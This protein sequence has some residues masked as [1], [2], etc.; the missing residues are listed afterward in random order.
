[1]T[2]GRSSPTACAPEAAA[3][4]DPVITGKGIS[5]PSAEKRL[6]LVSL[7]SALADILLEG[8]RYREKLTELSGPDLEKEI[9]ANLGIEPDSV[10][11]I[12]A[13]GLA[14]SSLTDQSIALFAQ[15]SYALA[16]SKTLE[17][18]KQAEFDNPLTAAAAWLRAGDACIFKNDSPAAIAYYR[19][20][21]TLAIPESSVRLKATLLSHLSRALHAG[22][23]D[24]PEKPASQVLLQQSLEAIQTAAT[25]IPRE[26]MPEWWALNVLEKARVLRSLA[27]GK[28]DTERHRLLSE[29]KA[30]ARLSLEALDGK[31]SPTIWVRAQQVLGGLCVDQ[32]HKLNPQERMPFLNE[33][34]DAYRSGL[35]V[36]EGGL[37]PARRAAMQHNLAVALQR[38]C[39]AQTTADGAISLRDA[40]KAYQ[41]SME[42]YT[43]EDYPLSWAQ[44]QT[45][46][47]LVCRMMASASKV[48]MKLKMLGHA[49]TA[50]RLALEVLSREENPDGWADAQE[51]LGNTFEAQGDANT[52]EEQIRLWQEAEKRYLAAAE[53]TQPVPAGDAT[54][55]SE[56]RRLEKLRGKMNP[57]R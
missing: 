22:A 48:E 30:A 5:T 8:P 36:L 3:G 47:G 41:D 52:G 26:T 46:L 37:N 10:S 31:V 44:A 9:A 2:T 53:K 29:G 51:G 25:L 49:E 4:W 43:R 55:S 39:F 54:P 18:A 32:A 24:N 38:R 16:E 20:A 28:P 19:A 21:L 45:Y 15:A 35:E 23:A 50:Y 11:A 17:A 13:N 42:F 1:M 33:A 57:L 40:L 34:V 27:Q 6:T 14:S 12:I 56:Q 7:D